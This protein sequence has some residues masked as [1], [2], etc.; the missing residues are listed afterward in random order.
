VQNPSHTTPQTKPLFLKQRGGKGRRGKITIAYIMKKRAEYATET[1]R[2]RENIEAR[3]FNM[4]GRSLRSNREAPLTAPDV[5]T[6]EEG[7][8]GGSSLLQKR[9]S[10]SPSWC[11]SG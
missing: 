3:L 4:G 8:K 6:L 5:I 10:L 7:E 9:I 1:H 2:H 11:S